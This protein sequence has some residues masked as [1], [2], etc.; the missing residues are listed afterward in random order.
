MHPDAHVCI[1][2]LSDKKTYGRNIAS[3][4]LLVLWRL[5][6]GNGRH[7]RQ[8]SNWLDWKHW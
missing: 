8:R 1:E 3:E 2:V 4:H 6:W 7:W 5:L